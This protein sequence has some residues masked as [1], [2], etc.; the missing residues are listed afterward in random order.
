MKRLLLVAVILTVLV[1]VIVVG[2]KAL[3]HQP[4]AA[5]VS[6]SKPAV[7]VVVDP[8]HGG[9]DP[10]ANSEGIFEK[11]VTLA[12]ANR[13]SALAGEYPGLK[14][15]LTRS[16]D[17]EVISDERIAI[18]NREG[19]ALYVAIHVNAFNKPTATGIETW[20]DT[21]HTSGDPSWT[22]ARSVEKAVVASTAAKDRGVRTQD[23]FLKRL[24]I[25]AAATEVGFITSPD[26]R[27]K[28]LDP[29]Y[30]DL[31]ARGIL[32]GVCDYVTTAGITPQAVTGT[33]PASSGARTGSTTPST[34]TPSSHGTQGS[35]ATT[36]TGTTS[37]QLVGTPQGSASTTSGTATSRNT[38]SASAAPAQ[39]QPATPSKPNGPTI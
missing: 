23:L 13:V 26:E 28:L 1:V 21:T 6:K 5:T 14:I 9:R 24:T 16:T 38:P 20:V 8:A 19:A 30:Q 35:A 34:V 11:D 29:T 12:V 15:I 7:V 32:Q 10:G 4:D 17:A 37:T 3:R 39:K 27:T 22:F 36:G 18:A 25:P 31:V 2:I 33:T